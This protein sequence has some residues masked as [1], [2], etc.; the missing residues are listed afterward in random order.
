MW[1]GLCSGSPPDPVEELSTMPAVF[2]SENELGPDSTEYFSSLVFSLRTEFSLR[3]KVL[4]RNWEAKAGFCCP[5]SCDENPIE[6]TVP[7]WVT[8]TGK[9]LQRQHRPIFLSATD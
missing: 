7:F 2:Y 9:S 4:E 3:F 1:G 5:P 6:G 8:V